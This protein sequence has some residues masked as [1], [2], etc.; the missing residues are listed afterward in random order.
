MPRRSPCWAWSWAAG[1]PRP[2]PWPPSASPCRACH[3]AGA[4]RGPAPTAAWLSLTAMLLLTYAAAV[5]VLGV[6]L[7]NRSPA[8]T[9]LATVVVALSFVPLR[10]RVQRVVDHRFAPVRQ[11]GVRLLRAFE[12][13]VRAG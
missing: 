9:A 6:V 5:A 3:S 13:D 4:S 10:R 7:G 11:K 8:A 1:A 12:D 2:P